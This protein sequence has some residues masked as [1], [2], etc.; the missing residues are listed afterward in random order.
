LARVYKEM[1]SVIMLTARFNDTDSFAVYPSGP[2]K[3]GSLYSAPP[4]PIKPPSIAIG[5][6]IKKA[7]IGL[8][9]TVS[10]SVKFR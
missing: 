2:F 1:K 4:S 7:K 8:R 5:I 6:E 3:T 9:E 10:F